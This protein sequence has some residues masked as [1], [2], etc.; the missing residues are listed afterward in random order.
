M[1]LEHPEGLS[2]AH[3]HQVL[4][5]V[6]E[7][8]T[9][10]AIAAAQVDDWAK[11]FESAI[12]EN[13]F[14]QCNWRNSIL[15]I[16]QS[17]A[18]DQ[19]PNIHAPKCSKRIWISFPLIGTKSYYYMLSVLKQQGLGWCS[20][21]SSKCKSSLSRPCTESLHYSQHLHWYSKQMSIL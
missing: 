10:A 19:V 4:L 11:S 20:F 16:Q 7:D 18:T 17:K 5:P 2:V 14:F 6:L 1:S 13:N 12:D 3:G 8:D 15:G 9:A 21:N